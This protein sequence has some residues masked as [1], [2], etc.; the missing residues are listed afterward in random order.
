MARLERTEVPDEDAPG[1]G[2]KLVE[3]GDDGVGGR[4]LGTQHQGVG[5]AGTGLAVWERAAGAQAGAQV[6]ANERFTQVGIAVQDD[7]FAQGNA[8][9]PEPGNGVSDDLMS[10]SERHG[11]SQGREEVEKLRLLSHTE[12]KNSRLVGCIWRAEVHDMVCGGP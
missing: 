6:Q 10:E 5:G 11:R 2:T 4:V 7:Q 1:I 12:V 8:L 3:A 9:R